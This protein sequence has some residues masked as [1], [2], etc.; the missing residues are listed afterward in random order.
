MIDMNDFQSQPLTPASPWLMQ[1][2]VLGGIVL[3]CLGIAASGAAWTNTSLTTWY[4]HLNK[5]AWNPPNWVFGPV[6]TTLYVL[7][8]VAAW[9][10]W[11]ERGWREGSM[12]LSVF[13]AQLVL[14]AAW[15]WLFF[16]MRSPGLAFVD[17]VLLWLAILATV[18]T[19]WRVSATAGGLLLPYLAWVSFAV[20]LNGAIWRLNP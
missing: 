1:G 12:P 7:M 11:R 4:A 6:W 14:N 19:F 5:P 9:L 13:A 20:A 16:G 18:I 15:S 8:A 3:L 10:V 17:I 2:S